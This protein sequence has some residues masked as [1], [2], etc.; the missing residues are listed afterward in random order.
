MFESAP[1]ESFI[2]RVLSNLFPPKWPALHPKNDLSG[3][4]E[5][6]GRK[7]RTGVD[8]SPLMAVGR[9]V[10]EAQPRRVLLMGPRTSWT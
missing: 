9:V 6:Q 5:Y 10:G 7:S 3:S 2:E 1:E 4:L 8:H